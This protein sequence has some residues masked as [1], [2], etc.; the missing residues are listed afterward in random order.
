VVGLTEAPVE[1]RVRTGRRT[2]GEALSPRRNS[3][4]FLRLMLAMAVIVD[5]STAFGKFGFWSG[6]VSYENMPL[7][8]LAVF[9]FFGI[10]G[11]LIT[12]SAER[13]NAGRYLWQRFLRI[14][15]GYWVCLIVMA[16]LFGILSWVSVHHAACSSLSCYFSANNG[17]FSFLYRNA[18]LSFNQTSIS[19]TPRGHYDPFLWGRWNSSLWTLYFEFFCYLL[20]MV[21]ALTRL[22]RHRVTVLATTIVLMVAIVVITFTP[23][24]RS[25]FSLYHWWIPMNMMK[26]AAIFLVGA[27]IYLYRDRIPD[28][29]WLALGCLAVFVA[30][31]WLPTPDIHPSVTFT[32]SA[33]MAPVLA[34]PILWL[35]A[36]LP[37]Q[38]VGA[39]NDYSYGFYIYA[40]P[41]QQILAIWGVI[42]LGYLPYTAVVIVVTAPFA[43]GSWWLIERHAMRLKK[44]D[45]RHLRRPVPAVA[46][47]P[48]TKE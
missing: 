41:V 4:N 12:G 29:G 48:A 34:Y 28:S 3:L 20:L 8:T 31:L 38:K 47:Q 32:G 36:H 43:I 42:R 17:P 24:Y 2:F 30:C 11:Y 25:Q 18:L 35:G 10:S 27:L 19:G 1:E 44:F 16:F 45:P 22:L 23:S 33:I 15:P 13:N 37:F 6:W 9:G 14:F 5:H 40:F 39:R 26:F 21:L 7:G 46:G